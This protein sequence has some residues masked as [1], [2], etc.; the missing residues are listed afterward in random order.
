MRVYVWATYTD[1]FTALLQIH[2]PPC[3]V[4]LNSNR[5]MQRDAPA[6]TAQSLSLLQ[7]LYSLPHSGVFL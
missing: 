4:Q 1:A 3:G 6:L 7:N 5:P 2:G